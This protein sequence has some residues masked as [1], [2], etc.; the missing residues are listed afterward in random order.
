M[1]RS[2]SII[3]SCMKMYTVLFITF[4]W[5][6]LH[7]TKYGLSKKY[8]KSFVCMLLMLPCVLQL[9]NLTGLNQRR[10]KSSLIHSDADHLACVMSWRSIFFC[11][12]FWFTVWVWK[13][14]ILVSISKRKTLFVTGQESLFVFT[15]RTCG[16]CFTVQYVILLLGIKGHKDV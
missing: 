2:H 4:L 11:S 1:W 10:W 13:F 6:A 7:F 16:F 14:W 8:E 5:R 15:S 9:K 12:Y 3:E